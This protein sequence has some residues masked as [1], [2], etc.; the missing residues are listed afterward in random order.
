MKTLNKA[1]LQDFFRSYIK[2]TIIEIDGQAYAC[3]DWDGEK[4]LDC[5][6]VDAK[7]Y[8]HIND[9]Q[10]SIDY[11]KTKYEV[12]DENGKSRVCTLEEMQKNESII[13]VFNEFYRIE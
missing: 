13:Q 8:K 6:Q 12:A 7:T 11:Y 2:I 5:W 1:E 4:W 10:I 3:T 9:C